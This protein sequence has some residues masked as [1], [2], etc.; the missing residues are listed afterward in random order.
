MALE[1]L[2]IDEPLAAYLDGL[3]RVPPYLEGLYRE[4]EGDEWAQM[5]THPDLG[6]LLE[7]LVR[8]TGGRAVLEIG[9]FVGTS[10]AW[11]AQ[12]L[13]EGGRVDTLE[14]SPDRAD[15][16]EAFLARAGLGDRV[17]VHRGPA[18]GTLPALPDGAYGLCYI[19]ADKTGYPAYLDQA[20]RLVRP[21]GLILADNVLS[22]GRVALPDGERGESA[23]ALAAFTRAAL[24]HPRLVTTV[25][26]IGDGVSL[27][28]VIEDY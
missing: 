6:V 20:V 3:A 26:T 12:A 8:A 1:R 10:A 15:R 9:T 7:A 14:A 17:R 23:E 18:A 4:M 21:G 22:G 16:A 5:M 11:M 19:D 27:S 24:D 28:A 2:P 25:L 13:A